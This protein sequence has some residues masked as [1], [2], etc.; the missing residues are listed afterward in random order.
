ME[1][2]HEP[3]ASTEVPRDWSV[4][5]VGTEDIKEVEESLSSLLLLHI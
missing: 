4:E 2:K 5:V 3:V 1:P